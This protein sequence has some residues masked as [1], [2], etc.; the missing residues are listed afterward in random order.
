V[1]LETE[2]QNRIVG[3]I[4]TLIQECNQVNIRIE[5]SVIYVGGQG[6]GDQTNVSYSLV[7]HQHTFYMQM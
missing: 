2:L 5:T 7:L 3:C 4:I 6:G 1:E